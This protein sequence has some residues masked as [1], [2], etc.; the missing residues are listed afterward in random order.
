MCAIAGEISFNKNATNKN[1][2]NMLDEMLH[3]GPDGRGLYFHKNLSMGMNRLAIVDLTTGDQPLYNEDKSV[4]VVGNGEIYNYPELQ[5]KLKKKGHGLKS[6]SDIETVV[7]LYEDYGQNFVKYLRGMFALALYDKNKNRLILARDRIGEKPLYYSSAEDGI[8]FASELKAL[9][10]VPQTNKTVSKKRLVEYFHYAYINDPNTIFSNIHRIPQASVMTID[11]SRRSQSIKKY[12]HVPKTDKVLHKNITSEIEDTIKYAS[13]INSRAD[14]PVGISLSGG[15]DST[16]VLA[17]TANTKKHKPTT[18]FSVGYAGHPKTDERDKAKRTAKHYAIQ[19]FDVELSPND[20]VRDYPKIVRYSDE[21][22]ADLAAY[23]IYS[24]AKMCRSKKIKV[25]LGGLGG[26]EL[27]W[28]Y[29]WVNKVTTDYFKSGTVDSF[30]LYL[31]GPTFK[32]CLMFTKRLFT[33]E[34]KEISSKIPSPSTTDIHS[35]IDVGRES[36]R[37]LLKGWLAANCL[38]LADRLGMANSVEMRSPL[39]DYKL[40]ELAYRSQ[41]NITAY[42]KS[43][44]FWMKKALKNILPIEVLSRKKQGFTPPVANWL[45]GLFKKYIN[46]LNDGYLVQEGVLDANRVK[47]LSF[48]WRAVPIYWEAIYHVLTLEIWCRIYIWGQKTKDL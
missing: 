24:V 15:I 45:P 46:L 23:P 38:T 41:E 10:K 18:S 8:Y 39:I 42:D 43:P 7:H 21:P 29:P 2:V 34:A 13:V 31:Q 28:G 36:I 1:T 12:W 26:D 5:K 25:L 44:K 9:L 48:T 40:V 14:V 32:R 22:V 33:K 3:R 16:S 4:V 35:K 20:F 11:I 30:N 19:N 47:L 27:F 37:E 6:G 17:F